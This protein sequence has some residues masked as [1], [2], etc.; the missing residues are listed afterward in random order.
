MCIKRERVEQRALFNL[1]EVP[2][3]TQS[4]LPSPTESV[5][6]RPLSLLA[7]SYTDRSGTTLWSLGCRPDVLVHSEEIRWIELRLHRRE[8]PVVVAVGRREARFALV[9]HH[10]VR[11]GATGPAKSMIGFGSSARIALTAFSA[12]AAAPCAR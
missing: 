11:I 5:N 9:V 4:L 6:R 12:S 2:S 8:T 10:E 3:S 7:D 1:A